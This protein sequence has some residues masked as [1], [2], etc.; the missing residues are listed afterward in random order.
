MVEGKKHRTFCHDCQAVSEV[1]GQL[2]MISIVVIAFATIGVAV[3][4]DGG[5]VKPEHIPHT[6]LREN[7]YRGSNNLQIVHS[8]GEAIDR[9]AIKIILSGNYGQSDEFSKSY[10]VSDP[11]DPIAKI[12]KPDG[13]VST[14]NFFMFGDCI[15]INTA[16][17]VIDPITHKPRD[18]TNKD[19]IDMFFIDMP[20]Q[21]AI[22]KTVLQKGTREPL[23]WITP[24]P[25]GSVYD[26]YGGWLDTES[27]GEIDG[28]FT[29][30]PIPH[31]DW[32]YED[33]T[34]GIDADEMGISDPLGSI[35]LKI[36]YN[37]GDNS[38]QNLTL[39]IYNGSSW[40]QL[41]SKMGETFQ[42]NR[43]IVTYP[44]DEYVSNTAQLESLIVKFSAIGNAANQSAKV[45]L[46]DF[47]GI[48]VN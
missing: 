25:Y 41:A 22:Q 20:S 17:I 27:V 34:F 46:V 47:V 19:S 48:Q 24:H 8:G 30:S 12:L 38:P 23:D 15:T 7:F 37:S 32:V 39:T 28:T 2:L 11:N 31:K 40:T 35:L 3:F 42:G 4:S 43:T 26:S 45:D 16:G 33:Y 10:T 6:D 5:A 21:Q 29:K 13:K 14:D 1:Y 9:S 18:L 44:I 36:I